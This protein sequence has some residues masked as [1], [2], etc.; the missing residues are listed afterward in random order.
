MKIKLK[1]VL[2]TKDGMTSIG[3]GKVLAIGET[4]VVVRVTKSAEGGVSVGDLYEVWNNWF[5]GEHAFYEIK[6]DFFKV[7]STYKYRDDTWN[8]PKARYKVIELIHLDN[9]DFKGDSDVAVTIGTDEFGGQWV[10]NFNKDE[11]G[12]LELA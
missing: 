11:F 10:E 9:P 12:G 8:D 5:E 7:G 4:S 6:G 1:D 3:E 2:V